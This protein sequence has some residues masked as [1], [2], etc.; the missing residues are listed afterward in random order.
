MH[1]S[2]PTV[3]KIVKQKENNYVFF[4]EKISFRVCSHSCE[5][6]TVFQENECGEEDYK[7]GLSNLGSF[8]HFES[9]D[10][11]NFFEKNF[12]TYQSLFSN[13]EFYL[14]KLNH[15]LINCCNEK[16]HIQ[17]GDKFYIS[18]LVNNQVFIV[19]FEQTSGNFIL[20]RFEEISKYL[21]N[22]KGSNDDFL[23]KK[24]QWSLEKVPITKEESILGRMNGSSIPNTQSVKYN[25]I[26]TIK[27]NNQQIVCTNKVSTNLKMQFSQLSI[28]DVSIFG[29]SSYWTIIPLKIEGT[30]YPNWFLM[31]NILKNKKNYS[32][33]FLDN[34]IIEKLVHS[35]FNYLKD[36]MEPVQLDAFELVLDRPIGWDIPSNNIPGDNSALNASNKF[37]VKSLNS[38][39][40]ITGFV[41]DHAEIGIDATIKHNI[42]P[43]KLSSFSIKIQEQ[44]ILEDILNCLVC[45]SGNYIKVTELIIEF[46]HGCGHLDF[47]SEDLYIF[48]FNSTQDHEKY[49]KL[50]FIPGREGISLFSH[51]IFDDPSNLKYFSRDIICDKVPEE[52]KSENILDGSLEVNN[53]LSI[54]HFKKNPSL[55]PLSYKTLE[56][57]NLHR[58]IRKFL[59]VHESGNSH[60]GIISGTLCDSFRELLKHFTMKITKF[61]SYLRKGQ[62]TIQNIWTYSQQA[63]VTLKALDF[64]STQVLYKKGCEMIDQVYKIANNEFKGEESHKKITNFV[65]NQLFLSWYK[66]FLAPWLKFG[67]VLDNFLEF[68]CQLGT[69][70]R[71]N[72]K[73]IHSRNFFREH[74]R[75]LSFILPSFINELVVQVNYIG[76]VSRFVSHINH[77]HT[78]NQ[79][80]DQV[81]ES[82]VLYFKNLENTLERMLR[83]ISNKSDLIRSKEVKV[84]I[85]T[86]F[87]ES[88]LLIYR[89]CNSI[90]D[91]SH[92][93]NTFYEIFLCGNDSLIQEFIEYIHKLG[94]R[95]ERTDY[96]SCSNITRKWS[97]LMVKYYR[98]LNNSDSSDSFFCKIEN[99]LITECVKEELFKPVKW[100]INSLILLEEELK[101]IQKDKQRISSFDAFKYLTIQ[102]HEIRTLGFIWSREL[103]NKYEAIFRLIFHLKYINHLLNSIWIAH[104]TSN[105]WD[106][107]MDKMKPSISVNGLICKSYLLRQKMLL[108]TTGI[109]EYIY[110]DVIVPLWRSMM[111]NLKN[112]TTLEELNSRQDHLLNEILTQCFFSESELLHSLYMILSLCHL[113]VSH[114]NLLN[115]YG[116]PDLEK[117]ISRENTQKQNEKHKENVQIS[118][119]NSSSYKSG[120]LERNKGRLRTNT[121]IK[122]LLIDTAYINIVEKFGSKFELLLCSFFSKISNC[123]SKN[124]NLINK[125]V[126]RLNYSSYYTEKIPASVGSWGEATLNEDSS[127]NDLFIES[128]QN[129][130][131]ISSEIFRNGQSTDITIL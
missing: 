123:K 76:L 59:K 33:K 87:R 95:G 21:K 49:L 9:T 119:H 35:Q 55:Y 121:H 57:S 28:G 47:T 115:I 112:I 93:I 120:H 31:K 75:K 71:F 83:S 114:S 39:P 91:I 10:N 113:F 60:F 6:L 79:S 3:S 86:I 41:F 61:E 15:L 89:V 128:E 72:T 77:L 109:L 65:F 118:K 40:S 4:G 67:V 68:N 16:E 45:N 124:V 27:L 52:S 69:R 84:Y 126:L 22:E 107:E 85:N 56:L 50:H 20:S 94:F 7:L 96:Y 99:N 48:E 54:N 44:L 88:Q 105:I 26:F 36:K 58:R 12:K 24:Y 131:Q 62:L 108:L 51:Q 92:H 53:I 101:F 25:E 5:Y 129:F 116:L 110:Q 125:L 98:D 66:H 82:Q 43:S 8:E 127:N 74:E 130:N 90:T 63:L 102:F 122:G 1:V 78:Q 64:I 70:K 29:R 11:K 104:Q 19:G 111:Q 97:E 103:L 23:L 32:L 14:L 106:N 81:H 34:R 18:S 46:F 2:L 30:V 38:L 13:S 17:Y 73:N 100:E 117:N 42:I 37:L 80:F